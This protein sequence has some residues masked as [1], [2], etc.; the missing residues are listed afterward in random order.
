MPGRTRDSNL[1]RIHTH[2]IMAPECTWGRRRI[3]ARDSMCGWAQATGDIGTIRAR[4]G[5]NPRAELLEQFS[6]NAAEAAVAEHAN[7]F[8]ALRFADDVR[9]DGVHVRQI[10]GS[11]AGAG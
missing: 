6:V 8:P 11:F 5:L 1:T 7:D 2:I 3:T 4:A 9:H 10:G